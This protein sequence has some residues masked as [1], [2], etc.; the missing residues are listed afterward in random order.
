MVDQCDM[1]YTM[2]MK[3]RNA[4][5]RIYTIDQKIASGRYPNSKQLAEIFEVKVLT[6]SRDIKFMKSN[7]SAPIK[8]D[9]LH[10]GYYYSEKT[11]RLPGAFTSAEEMQAI[12]I[13]KNLLS[14]YKDT[15][16]CDAAQQL[17]QNITAP[18]SDKEQ[19]NWFENRIVVPPIASA[20]VVSA[21]WNTITEGLRKNRNITFFYLNAWDDEY[22]FRR[23]RPYQ[24]LFDSGVW[25]LYGYSEERS[26]VRV[27]SLFRMKTVRLTDKAFVLPAD[28]SYLAQVDGSYF[29]VFRGGKKERYR[30]KFYEDSIVWVKERRWAADQK[31]TDTRDGTVISFTSSQDDK[32]LRWV[33]SG[34]CKVQP[35]EPKGLVKKWRWHINEIK[36]MQVPA[37]PR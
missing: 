36:K 29:G 2:N 27:F 24:L 5:E 23:V 4:L 26:D 21:V 17:L 3:T 37:R 35:L 20:P 15:P 8:Y 19:P 13:A 10:R 1:C 28:F 31:I 30:I 6:I 9:S 33:L 25:F 16:I 11:F 32:V 14:I 22:Q 12:G 18:L 34:G 7:L